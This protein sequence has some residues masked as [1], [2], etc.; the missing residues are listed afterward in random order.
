MQQCNS[1]SRPNRMFVGRSTNPELM[2][3]VN[4]LVSLGWLIV[5]TDRYSVTFTT[6]SLIGGE[7]GWI[8]VTLD[9]PFSDEEMDRLHTTGLNSRHT[10]VWNDPISFLSTAQEPLQNAVMAIL[11]GN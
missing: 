1:T 9:V 10:S 6:P 4:A 5:S 7:R 11:S 3:A 8:T 2:S